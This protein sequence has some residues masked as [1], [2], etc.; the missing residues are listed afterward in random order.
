MTTYTNESLKNINKKDL[1]PTILSPQNKLEEVNNNVLVEMRRL[2]ES[3]S[4]SQAEVSMRKQ[5]NILLSSRLVSI[6]RHSWL[7]TQYSRQECLEIVGIPSEVEGDALEEKVV[8]TFVKLGCKISTERI[9]A[10]HRI[11]K[12]NPIV[13][14]KFLRRKYCLQVLDVK[15]DLQKIKLEEIDLPGQNKLFIYFVYITR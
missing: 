13:I 10:C 9:E 2:N 7:N 6:E 15:R 3:F 5:V 12:K 14:V 8:A 1:I 4:K 11:S